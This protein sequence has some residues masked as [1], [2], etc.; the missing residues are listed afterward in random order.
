MRLAHISDLHFGHHD[1]ALAAGLAAEIATQSPDLIVV[2][3]DFTQDGTAREFAEARAFL[4]TL[5]QPVFAIP[6][7]HDMP[8]V[9]I[10]RRL[11]TPYS[12]YQRYIAEELEPFLEM[13]GVAIAGLKT[14]RRARFELNWAHGS[15]SKAQLGKLAETFERASPNAVRVV[16]A[17]HPLLEPEVQPSVAMQP[18]RKAEAAL[19][20]FGDLGVRLVLSGHFHLSY[21][22]RHAPGQIR[23][24]VPPGPREAAVAPILVAQASSTISTRLR[25]EPNAYNVIDIAGGSIEIAVRESR[26]GTWSTREDTLVEQL[27]R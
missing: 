25:G 20:A 18:V 10:V 4:D 24:G 12:L 14:A 26:D 15:I 11:L 16:V 23:E 21:V 22:R 8:A 9:N 27:H 5:K 17:H 13:G 6:G 1:P 3:G 19:K 2:S 7:N